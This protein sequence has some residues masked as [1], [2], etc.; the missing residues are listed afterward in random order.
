MTEKERFMYLLMGKISESNAPIVFKGAMVTKLIL[1]ENG[2]T[3]LER[4][5]KDIDANW[6]GTP[7]SMNALVDTVNHSLGELK[8]QIYAIAFREYGEKM[9]AGISIREKQTDEEIISMDIDMRPIHG[10]RIYHYGEIGFRG[11]LV[12]EVLADKLTVLSKKRIFRRVKDMVDIYALGHCVKVNTAA[13]F[14]MFQKNP[15]REVGVF[16]E[17]VHRRQDV[18]HAYERLRGIENKPPFDQVYQYLMRF[19]QPFVIRDM[20]P[21]VWNSQRISWDDCP[22]PSHGKNDHEQ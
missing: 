20:T 19:I 4:Q 6:V 10:S 5:T 21:Q 7:P 15:D 11:V 2:Y 1:A 3:A 17:F 18:E 16:D 12:D 9:S 22:E 14:E 13:I 8:N